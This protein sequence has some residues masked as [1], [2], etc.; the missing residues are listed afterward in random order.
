MFQEGLL[1]SNIVHGSTIDPL[2]IH[3]K[4]SMIEHGSILGHI[5][6]EIISTSL[7]RS[8]SSKFCHS[9]LLQR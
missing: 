2:G 7:F 3:E 9:L 4:E 1:E 8:N 6:R 5:L